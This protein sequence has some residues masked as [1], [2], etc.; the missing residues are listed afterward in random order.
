[1]RKYFLAFALLFFASPASALVCNSDSGFVKQLGEITTGNILTLADDCESLVDTGTP[2]STVPGTYYAANSGIV[3]DGLTDNTAAF[4]QLGIDV[5]STIGVQVIFPQGDCLTSLWNSFA[6]RKNFRIVGQAGIDPGTVTKGTRIV[7]TRV[8]AAICFDFSNSRGMNYENLTFAWNS[9][10]YSGTLMTIAQAASSWTACS[11]HNVQFQQIGVQT[12][13]AAGNLYVRNVV[14]CNF[15]NTVFMHAKNGLIGGFD[16]EIVTDTTNITCRG[17]KFGPILNHAV[18]NPGV[19]WSFFGSWFIASFAGAPVGIHQTDN[20]YIVQALT[21]SGTNFTDASIAGLNNCSGAAICGWI[22]LPSYRGVSISGGALGGNLIANQIGI[23]L[24]TGVGLSIDGTYFAFLDK[25]ILATGGLVGGVVGGSALATTVTPFTGLNAATNFLSSGNECTTCNNV[26]IAAGKTVTHNA[27]TTFGGTDGKTLNTT[28]SG[29]LGGSGD[30]WALAI[31]AGKSVSILNSM[32]LSGGGFDGN[33]YTFPNVTGDTVAL[34][35]AVQA[36]TNKTYNGNTWTAGTG[37]LTIAAG[38]TATHNNTTTFAGTDGKTVTFN[39][40]ITFAGT[41]ATTMTFPTTSQSIPGLAIAN[42]F[43]ASQA[44]TL[45]QASQTSISVNNTNASTAA[46]AA[47][48][49]SS[50]SGTFTAA[51]GNNPNTTGQAGFTWTGASGM[52]FAA[53]HA[54][55]PLLFDT[56]G[57]NERMRISAAGAMS[58]GTTTDPGSPGIILLTS[59]L[60]TGTATVAGLPA[61]GAGTKGARHFVTDANATFT[62]GIG[63]AVVGGGANNVPVTCDGGSWRIGANDNGRLANGNVA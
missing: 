34:L 62:A 21:V 1:M 22:D 5:P 55:G 47:L 6:S 36:L 25:G 57:F 11:F 59:Y 23:R 50:N 58:V 38:K 61:C 7:C 35:A 12:F 42:T 14:H 19:E 39:N 40:S 18:L 31:Q 45:S 4:V 26:V 16:T 46:S 17:C 56:G 33:S 41:D 52:L 30:G 24:G 51:A 28:N 29:T 54:S 48:V 2:A 60:Q 37:T 53:T 43:T 3:C 27:T 15:E 20:T 8:D 10:V 13:T 49:A 32:T 44:V 9:G 63:A